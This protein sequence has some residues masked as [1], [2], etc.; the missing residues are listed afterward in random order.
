V[1]LRVPTE[2][3]AP[4]P[5]PPRR[6]ADLRPYQIQDL[7]DHIPEIRKVAAGTDV[8]FL[9]RVILAEGSLQPSPE[10]I[11]KLNRLLKEIDER[12]EVR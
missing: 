5:P 3:P 11:E 9:F 4:P 2:P 10:V 8:R 6:E 12:L 7:A 1:K